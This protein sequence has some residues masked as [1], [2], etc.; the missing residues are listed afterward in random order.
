MATQLVGGKQGLEAF[1]L[2][3]IQSSSLPPCGAALS[4]TGPLAHFFQ[5]LAEFVHTQAEQG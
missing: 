2:T 5:P 4:G 1:P 3:W